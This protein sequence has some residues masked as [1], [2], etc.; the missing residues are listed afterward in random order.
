MAHRYPA[1]EVEMQRAKLCGAAN[2]RDFG[3]GALV[4]L[5]GGN[6]RAQMKMDGLDSGFGA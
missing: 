1:A 6:I 2:L 5:H 3:N 4:N